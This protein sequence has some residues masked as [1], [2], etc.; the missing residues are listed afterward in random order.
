MAFKPTD[1]IKELQPPKQRI[2]YNDEPITGNYNK[3]KLKLTTNNNAFIFFVA[4]PENMC[5]DYNNNRIRTNR[6]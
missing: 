1:K 3:Q 2:L 6:L 5:L 4:I